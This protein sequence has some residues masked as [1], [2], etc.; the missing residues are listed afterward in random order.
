MSYKCPPV[1][2]KKYLYIQEHLGSLLC[3]LSLESL[4]RKLA[5]IRILN[6]A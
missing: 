3:D 2:T 6:F 5:M 4:P 1:G